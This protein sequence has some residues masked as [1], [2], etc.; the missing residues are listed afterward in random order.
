MINT[1]E[2]E[3]GGENQGENSPQYAGSNSR[4]STHK[5]DSGNPVA[6]KSVIWWIPIAGYADL[7]AISV[8][9][10]VPALVEPKETKSGTAPAPVADGQNVELSLRVSRQCKVKIRVFISA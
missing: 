8:L 5:I 9:D 2:I 4:T 10:I 1:F 3:V 7:S 6:S